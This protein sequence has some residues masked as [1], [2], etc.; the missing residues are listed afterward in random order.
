MFKI[1]FF[2]KEKIFYKIKFFKI[3]KIF[4]K[5]KMYKRLVLLNLKE[6]LL[7]I[8]KEKKLF[9]LLKKSSNKLHFD[10]LKMK[11]SIKN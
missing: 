2:K 9:N 8:E 7:Q 6:R 4:F 5:I 10:I 3:E 1:K 11:E